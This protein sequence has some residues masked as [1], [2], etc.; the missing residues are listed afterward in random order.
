MGNG[1]TAK[2]KRL[3]CHKAMCVVAKTDPN[4]THAG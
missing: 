2:N 3:A 4:L 1:Y